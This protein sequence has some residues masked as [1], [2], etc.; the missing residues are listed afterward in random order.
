MEET[1]FNSND[2]TNNSNNVTINRE[3]NSKSIS[4]SATNT[5][6][7][8]ESF[9]PINKRCESVKMEAEQ[10][11]STPI[12]PTMSPKTP[13]DD[14][15]SHS[16]TAILDKHEE[17]LQEEKEQTKIL[18]VLL[19]LHKQDSEKREEQERIGRDTLDTVRDVMGIIESGQVTLSSIAEDRDSIQSSSECTNDNNSL[20]MNMDAT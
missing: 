2:A 17:I 20:T 14:L 3:A 16:A 15:T 13:S 11:H 8:R 7:V 6:P 4:G 18:K 1:D 12:T 9:K 19:D 5:E 10:S